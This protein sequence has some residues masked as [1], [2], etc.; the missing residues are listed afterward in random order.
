MKQA[1]LDYDIVAKKV[2]LLSDNESAIKIAHNPVQ[3]SRTKHIVVC[4][5]F[6]RDHVAKGDIDLMHVGTN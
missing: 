5:N 3:H 1:L 6:I 4:H 2:P